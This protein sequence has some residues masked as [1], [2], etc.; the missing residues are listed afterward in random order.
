[1]ATEEELMREARKRAEDKVGFYKSFSAYVLVNLML[2]TIWW[3]TGH[4][5]PWPLFI[6]VFWGIGIVA[7]GIS[8]FGRHRWTDEA[9]AR[10]YEKLKRREMQ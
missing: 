9:T 10:E 4:G 7:Q 3:F 8:V 1:M 5:F 6:L 2:I